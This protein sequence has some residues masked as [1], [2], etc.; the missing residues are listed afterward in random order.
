MHD[1]SPK[2]FQDLVQFCKDKMTIKNPEK[3]GI[4]VNVVY[5]Y[6]CSM[7]IHVLMAGGSILTLFLT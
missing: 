6:G 2:L 1:L 3:S 5:L 7:D 4:K